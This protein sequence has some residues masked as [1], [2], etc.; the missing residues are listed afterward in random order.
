M[1]RRMSDNIKKMVKEC[2]EISEKVRH[3]KKMKRRSQ[4]QKQGQG[5]Q[6]K[7]SKIIERKKLEKLRK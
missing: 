3:G 1:N 2:R 4:G 7:M 6:Q 5:S